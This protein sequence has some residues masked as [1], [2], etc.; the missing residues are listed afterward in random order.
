MLQNKDKKEGNLRVNCSKNQGSTFH[1]QGNSFFILS[2]PEST[3]PPFESPL[4]CAIMLQEKELE[5]M[6]IENR[7]R[8]QER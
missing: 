5:L 8:R 1:L 4:S 6:R 7:Q 3:V 2:M